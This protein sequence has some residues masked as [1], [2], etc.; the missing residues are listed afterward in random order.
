MPL[1][2]QHPGID[3]VCTFNNYED[4]GELYPNPGTACWVVKPDP[5]V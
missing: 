3:H 1:N 4:D 2:H 5:V